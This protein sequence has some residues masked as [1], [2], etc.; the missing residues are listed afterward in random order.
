MPETAGQL[1][2]IRQLSIAAPWDSR[3]RS[4]PSV[5]IVA[6]VRGVLALLYGDR[7][8]RHRARGVRHPRGRNA[9][10]L[11]P[12][13]RVASMPTTSSATPRAGARR[14]STGCSRPSDATTGVWLYYHRSII[15]ACLR[16]YIDYADP[17]LR[18]GSRAGW[19]TCAPHAA[20]L[21]GS[22]RRS[23][24]RENRAAGEADR[25]ALRLHKTAAHTVALLQMRP[26]STTACCS[27]SPR[28]G[29]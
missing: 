26:T 7:A 27:T 20:T 5:D 13:T 9:A 6:Q 28:C 16:L 17:K 4:G 1:S 8:G 14:P 2:S 24:E 19:T 29:S 11:L 22:A 25:R 10:R 18:L 23:R 12:R 15:R 3:G 21:A